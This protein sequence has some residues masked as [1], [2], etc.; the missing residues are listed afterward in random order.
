M[1]NAML[2]SS[3]TFRTHSASRS[4]GRLTHA[5]GRI[6]ARVACAAVLVA[7]PAVVDAHYSAVWSGPAAQ[8]TNRDSLTIEL[9][10]AERIQVKF[11]MKKGG[12]G[13]V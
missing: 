5:L 3:G 7:G 10:P 4:T 12:K 8:A 13:S 1:Q 11:Q 9:A 2:S 6:A